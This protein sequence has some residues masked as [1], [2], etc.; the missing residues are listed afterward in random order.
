MLTYEIQCHLRADV[1]DWVYEVAAELYIEV[2]ESSKFY[3]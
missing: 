2:N 1:F 3:L